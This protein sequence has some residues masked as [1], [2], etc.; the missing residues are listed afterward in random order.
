[1]PFR[2]FPQGIRRTDDHRISEFGGSG[3]GLLHALSRMGLYGLDIYLVQLLHEKLPVLRVNDGLDRGAEHTDI[4]FFKDSGTVQLHSAVQRSLASE[5]EQDALRCL[6]LNHLLH[7]IRGHR[8]EIYLVGNA[9]GSLH[10]G[11]VRIDEDSL[12]ALLLQRLQC[13]RT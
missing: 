13:L 10:G 3:L 6:L 8:Q 1:M 9:F 4:V 12:Y 5:R 7:E 2:R 11:N